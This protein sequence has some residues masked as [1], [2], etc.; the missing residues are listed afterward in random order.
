CG[1]GGGG[2][3]PARAAW[4]VGGGGRGWRA[5]PAAR[6][7]TAAPWHTA[8]AA[9]VSVVQGLPSSHALPTGWSV[10][11]QWPSVSHVPVVHELPSSQSASVA[12]AV[13][14]GAADRIPRSAR[15]PPEMPCV[16]TGT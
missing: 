5:P 9:Q 11:V 12:H 8:P 4:Q 13:V 16:A 2:R 6:G 1:G 10:N 7:G 3:G 14:N 15:R